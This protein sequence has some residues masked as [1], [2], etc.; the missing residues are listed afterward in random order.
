MLFC[1]FLGSQLDWLLL[2]FLAVAVN[3]QDVPVKLLEK[4]LDSVMLHNKLRSIFVGLC[5]YGVLRSHLLLD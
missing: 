4:H 5:V 1:L 2:N 3:K